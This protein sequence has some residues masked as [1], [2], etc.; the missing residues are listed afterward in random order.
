MIPRPAPPWLPEAILRRDSSRV[1]LVLTAIFAAGAINSAY[2]PLWFADHGLTAAEIGLVLGAASGLRVICGPG[3]GWVADRLGRRRAVLAGAA[4][5][6]ALAAAS[7]P[8]L[9]GLTSLLLAAALLGMASALLAPLL[10][11]L[12]LALASAGRLEYG[13]TRAWGSVS[14]MVATAGAGAALAQGGTGL[15]PTLLAAGYTGAAFFA[16]GL[17]DIEPGPRRIGGLGALF[18]DRAFVLALVATALIQGSHAAYYAFA[19]LHWRAAGMGD[20]VIGLLVAEGIVAEIALFLWGRGLVQ[21]L[22]AGRLTAVAAIACMVRWTALAF[23][24]SVPTL[25]LL[26]PL[27]AATFAFQHLST[28]LVLARIAPHRAG[29]AQTLMSAIGFSAATAALVWLTGQLYGGWH[30]LAFLPMAG[31]GGAAL[32]VVRPLMRAMARPAIP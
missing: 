18:H 19:A 30:G 7:L 11:A 9:H 27:H 1:G 10:D 26:Q 29:M 23:A 15:V 21:R 2:L 31:F 17:P 16:M 4:A 13:P 24:T 14:Y 22:G 12:T 32:L 25:A 5:M 8:S 3:G 6:A 20:T 28:M